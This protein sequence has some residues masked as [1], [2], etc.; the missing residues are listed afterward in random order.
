MKTQT[1]VV[2]RRCNQ[3]CGFCARV[4][5]DAADPSAASLASAMAEAVAGGVEVVVLSGGEPLLRA[6]LG[7]LARAA[8]RAGARE[9]VLETNGS[10][11]HSRASA[12]ALRE[13]GISAVQISLVTSHPERHRELVSLRLPGVDVPPAKQTR[14]VH[15]F[16]GLRACL[17]AALP[18]GVRL[19][20]AAG[21]PSAASR[22]AGLHEAFP[23]L[24]RFVLAPTLP[25]QAT[26]RAEQAL[27]PRELADELAEAHRA[28]SRR[29]LTVA[30]AT[31]TPLPPC[32]VETEGVVRRLFAPL[33]RDEDGPANDA[34]LVCASCALARRCTVTARDLELAG[35]AVAARPASELASWLRPGKSPGSRLRVLG[36]ADVER[37]Y[38]V[39]YEY[40]GESQTPVS[41][42]GIVYRCNQ[43]CTFCE[44]A[45]MATDLAPEKVRAAIDASRARGSR[46][47]I[48]TGGEPTLSPH[49]VEHVRYARDRGF[50]Q[51]ELQ[52]NAVL[53][54]RPGA[55]AA[56]VGAGLTS[57]QISLHGADAQV[58]DQLTAAPGTHRRT[59]AGVDALLAAGVRVLLNH[60][61]FRDNCAA[62]VDF[63]EMVA[64]RWGAHRGRL[65][66]QFHSPRNEFPDPEEARLHVARYS[67]YAA[68]LAR[69][70][71]RARELGL[72]VRDLQDPTGIPSLCILAGDERYL[73]P[74]RAQLAAPRVHRWEVPWMTR[75]AAC[76]GC[77]LREACLGV[78]RHYLALHGDA[79]FQPVRLRPEAVDGGAL[80]GEPR[81][82]R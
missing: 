61:I 74:I 2:T 78:P 55:A 79:E 44:L 58:S 67:E 12:L 37:F 20:L 45:D 9:V 82:D 25:G 28:A 15:V 50:E 64:A 51:I 13:A 81:D 27:A 34:G 33:L 69:A 21:L 39:D 53:L 4:A 71:D 23:A 19:P 52:T 11:V 59:L 62:L 14:P 77:D 17:D 26:L 35:G 43:V 22:I 73:G 3:S 7:D 36:A 76:D 40:E 48:L 49:L 41:R 32:T 1:F 66:V 10:L 6:D 54:D 18:V 47:L 42:I 72:E 65:V 38:R 75:V 56:L 63:V 68:T 8:R 46:R 5:Y 57:A 31:D 29:R 16:R 24:G 70:I 30:L 80:R 60:L